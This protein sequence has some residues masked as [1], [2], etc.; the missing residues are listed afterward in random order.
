MDIMIHICSGIVTESPASIPARRIHAGHKIGRSLNSASS[1]IEDALYFS[2][3]FRLV[4]VSFSNSKSSFD[5][6][7]T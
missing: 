4:I 1:S 5:S 7:K 6:E 3:L 2:I